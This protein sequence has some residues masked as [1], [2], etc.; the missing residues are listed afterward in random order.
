MCVRGSINKHQQT[1]ILLLFQ[2]LPPKQS[3]IFTLVGRR[4]F[5]DERK[6]FFFCSLNF[7]SRCSVIFSVY[8]FFSFYS[9]VIVFQTVFVRVSMCCSAQDKKW[10]N[11]DDRFDCVRE[12]VG[13]PRYP[14][15]IVD[16]NKQAT[17]EKEMWE[18]P[19]LPKRNKKR[20]S[21][22][23]F[24]CCECRKAEDLIEIFLSFVQT[25]Q[26]STSKKIQ[27][28]DEIFPTFG[29]ST[30]RLWQQKKNLEESESEK[31]K[32]Y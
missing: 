1:L 29:L 18:K 32:I 10:K 28:V 3:R 16:T 2:C 23:Y 15:R 30:A 22:R 19:M 17:K 24:H 11:H 21:V 9:A 26:G 20:N 13:V 25:V 6:S 31:L 5:T 27:R 12:S 7:Q 14:R 4:E 8:R